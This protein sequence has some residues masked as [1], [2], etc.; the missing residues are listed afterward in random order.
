MA[1]LL[2]LQL[3]KLLDRLL[4]TLELL[5]GGRQ[6]LLVR[7]TNS[8]RDLLAISRVHE[9]LLLLLDVGAGLVELLLG[10]GDLGLNVNTTLDV[11]EYSSLGRDRI[12]DTA[13]RAG[14]VRGKDLDALDALAT[15]G[16]DGSNLLLD[17]GQGGVVVGLDDDCE[18]VRNLIRLNRRGNKK[19]LP[20]AS[21]LRA[22]SAIRERAALEQP[23]TSS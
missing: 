7:L 1:I 10:L 21:S 14:S 11:K 15:E 3:L 12:G 8:I 19:Y 4:E 23:R 16:L 9:D 13:S 22:Y 5:L 18:R 20:S 2:Q 6:L 17:G